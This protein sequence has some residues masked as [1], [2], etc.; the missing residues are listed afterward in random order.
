MNKKQVIVL[1]AYIILLFFI[2]IHLWDY[3]YFDIYTADYVLSYFVMVFFILHYF[4][5]NGVLSLESLFNIFGLL[6]SNYHISQLVSLNQQIPPTIGFAM[7][8]SHLSI[9]VFNFS[10]LIFRSKKKQTIYEHSPQYDLHTQNVLL[11]I[12]LLICLAT[13][14]YV[15]FQKIGIVAYFAAERGGKSLLM[16]EYSRLTFYKFAIPLVSVASLY[17]FFSERNRYSLFLFVIAFTVSLFNSILSASRAE[18]LSLFL[19]VLFLLKYFNKIKERTVIVIGGLAVVLFGAWK[20]L[21]WGEFDV[22]FDSE[23]NTWYE[24]CDR[25]LKIPNRELLYGQSYLTTLYNLIIPFTDSNT[26]STWYL[27]NY[28]WEVMVRGG[29]R[30]FSAVLEAYMNFDIFGIFLVYGFYGWL[31]S[32]LNT[33]TTFDTLVYLIVMISLFQFFRSESYSLW[34]N[35][36]WFKIYPL[37]VIYFVS[38]RFRMTNHKS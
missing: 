8:L 12:L 25:V 28:E 24:I 19:P 21:F 34:K 37:A 18:M 1:I 30:G 4:F 22:S 20:S 23:F 17:N 26:L 38:R 9:V 13:E 36:M 32:K 11:T 10:F 33:R 7:I 31:I 14:F 29:G 27:E 6:Y 16:A 3:Y 2:V 35:M 15:I 5:K